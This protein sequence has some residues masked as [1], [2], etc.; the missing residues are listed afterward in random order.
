MR[1]D[2]TTPL[3]TPCGYRHQVARVVISD[4]SFRDASNSKVIRI[5]RLGVCSGRSP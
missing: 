4:A 1:S 2:W 5:S 3:I